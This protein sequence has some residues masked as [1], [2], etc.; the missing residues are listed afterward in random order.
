MVWD[1]SFHPVTYLNP[2][3]G[4]GPDG[5][6][7][8]NLAAPPILTIV[9]GPIALPIPSSCTGSGYATYLLA[10]ELGNATPGSGITLPADGATDIAWCFWQP[11]G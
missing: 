8:P 11:R 10:F 3:S 1:M 2:F 7:Y 9:G 6:R 4:A 5:R